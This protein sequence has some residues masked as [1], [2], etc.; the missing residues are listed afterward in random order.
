[1]PST[2]RRPSVLT[3]TAMVTATETRGWLQGRPPAVRDL[4]RAE[5]RQMPIVHVQLARPGAVLADLPDVGKRD[6]MAR[7]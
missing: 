7:K 5:R 6:L 2:S 4:A 1:M 3:A